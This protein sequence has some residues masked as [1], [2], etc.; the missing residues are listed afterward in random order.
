MGGRTGDGDVVLDDDPIVDDGED[1]GADEFI[2]L[3]TCA[4]ED[5]VVDVPRSWGSGHVDEWRHEA[6]ERTGLAVWVGLV[7]V[8][9]E[10]LDLIVPEEQDPRAASALAGR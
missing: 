8:G 3:E 7:L 1:G 5:D 6:V 10:D 9:V 4:V 2:V